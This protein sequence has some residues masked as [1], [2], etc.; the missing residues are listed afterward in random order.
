MKTSLTRREFL[1]KSLAGTGLVLAAVATP[2]GERLLSAAEIKEEGVTFRPN[3]WLQVTP[4]GAVTVVVNKSEMGQ[5]VDTSLPMIVADELDADWHQVRFSVAPADI[6]YIDPVW[7]KQSTGGSTSI[8]HMYGTLRKAGAAGREMLIRAAAQ[9]WGV[10]PGECESSKGT[11]KHRPTGRTL[12]YGE[13]ASKAASLPVPKRPVLKKESQFAIM[14]KPL[15]RLDIPDK[16]HARA[17]FGIDTFIDGMLYASIE[18]PPVFGAKAVRY[19]AAA[20]LKV[21]GVRHVVPIKTGIAVCADKPDEAW[22]GRTALKTEWGKGA[23]PDLDNKT[24]GELFVKAMNTKGVVAKRRGD[25]DA[26]LG[27]AAKKLEA[28]FMLPYLSHATMETMDCTAHVRKDGCE[29][30]VPTQNQSGVVEVTEKETGL[31]PGKIMVHTTYLGGGFGRR[32]ETQVVK[33]AVAISKITGK[34]IKL[35]WTREE[36]MKNDYY[37]PGNYSKII[38]GLDEKGNLMAWSHKIVCPS[39]FEHAMPQMVKNGIDTEAVANLDDMK[40][41]VPNLYVEYVKF[42]TPIPVGF[43]RSVGSSHNGFTVESFMDEMAHAAGKDPLEFRL[44]LLKDQPRVSRVLKTVAEKAG[45]GNPVPKGDGRGIAYDFSFGSYVAQVAEVSVNRKDGTIKVHRVVAAIDC[46][47]IVNPAIIEAQLTGAI[48]MGLS[49]ALGERIDF[50][51]GGVE[52]SNFDTYKLLRM[53]QIP[54]KIE[55][56]IIKSGDSQGGVGEPG[57]PPLAPAVANAVFNAVGIRLRNLPMT[58]E[59]V[60]KALKDA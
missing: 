28:T 30:W 34:P 45:W 42:D 12:T 10:L 14:E 15:K 25:T 55:V 35:L 44:G 4:E 38:G 26:A 32:F 46:G 18:R 57:L 16:V 56:H 9:T 51:G 24:L 48:I 21:K 54:E 13:L 31:K 23:D 17:R 27:K 6:R 37:R 58:P 7:G 60:L 3:V 20:A 59:V 5:G 22:R 8:R 36:D 41:G 50:A 40:Y 47:P 11:V 53:S 52:T 29:I 43:W 33:E 49:A 1:Q 19:D 39:V 2:F